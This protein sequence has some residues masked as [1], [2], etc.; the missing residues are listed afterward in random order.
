MPISS[1]SG[2][3]CRRQ[4][5]ANPEAVLTEVHL[6]GKTDEQVQLLRPHIGTL[7]CG[8]ARATELSTLTADQFMPSVPFVS[9]QAACLSV[10]RMMA[11]AS[12]FNAGQENNLV[13]YDALFGPQAG[14]AR[15]HATA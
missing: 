2:W 1:P 7:M 6:V 15:F 3:G 4:D 9:L 12:S 11:I 14:H 10:G 13:Q 8:L 5:L